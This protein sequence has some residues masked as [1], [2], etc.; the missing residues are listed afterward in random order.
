MTW[1]VIVLAMSR[2]AWGVWFWFAFIVGVLRGIL[3]EIERG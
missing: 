1:A 3:D 2:E